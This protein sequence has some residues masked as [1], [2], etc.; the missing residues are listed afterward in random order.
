[1]RFWPVSLFSLLSLAGC[2][3]VH[4]KDSTMICVLFCYTSESEASAVV[5][6]KCPQTDEVLGAETCDIPAGGQ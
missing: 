4:F 5:K 1:M 6:E 2:G 3:A